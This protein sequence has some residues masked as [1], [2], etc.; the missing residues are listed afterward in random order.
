[1][2]NASTVNDSIWVLIKQTRFGYQK[3]HKLYRDIQAQLCHLPDAL[4]LNEYL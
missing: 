2:T 4:E 1:M 3:Q